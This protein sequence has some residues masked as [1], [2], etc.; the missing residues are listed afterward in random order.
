LKTLIYA[1]EPAKAKQV[2]KWVEVLGRHVPMEITIQKIEG[3]R[4]A[5]VEAERLLQAKLAPG[6]QTRSIDV[7]GRRGSPEESIAAETRENEYGL[8]A[9]TPAGRHGFI[10]LFYGSMVGH[11]VQRVSTSILVIREGPQVPP[12]RILACV[13]GARHSLTTVS[14]AAQVAG[15]FGAELS[16]LLVLSQVG[17]GMAGGDPW[18]TDPDTFLKSQD[19]LAKH[20]QV[21]ARVA[22]RPGKPPEIRVRQGLVSE[23]ILREVRERKHDLL[24]IGTHRAEDFDTV[25][26]D[27]TDELVQGSPVSTLV[28]GWKAALLEDP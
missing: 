5:S 12:K 23:E 21:A 10:R 4:G 25:Y 24:V 19:P 28:V 26:D 14:I 16:L 3:A 1:S 2:L 22:E 27:L 17:I 8:V 7:R 20:L 13:S 15:L 18:D 6:G 11:V 9:L